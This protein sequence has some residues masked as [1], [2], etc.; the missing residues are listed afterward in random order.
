M[1]NA[2]MVAKFMVDVK[3]KMLLAYGTALFRAVSPKREFFPQ[4]GAF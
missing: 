1:K 4:A 2:Q 3:R